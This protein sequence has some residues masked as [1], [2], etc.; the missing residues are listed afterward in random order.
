MYSLKSRNIFNFKAL[1][2]R[3]LPLFLT[4][5]S[6]GAWAQQYVFLYFP[7][8]NTPYFLRNN[9]G[10]IAR[11]AANTT[12]FGTYYAQCIFTGNS[13]NINQVTEFQNNGYYLAYGQDNY[14]GGV[15]YGLRFNNNYYTWTNAGNGRIHGNNRYLR[16]ANNQWSVENNNNPGSGESYTVLYAYT[17]N[18]ASLSGSISGADVLKEIGTSPYTISGTF[19]SQYHKFEGYR[20]PYYWYN[21]GIK[22]SAPAA[23]NV[24]SGTWSLTGGG[25]YASVNTSTGVITVSSLPASDIEMTLTCSVT[26][27]GSTATVS[28]KVILYASMVAA[29][30]ITRTTNNITLATD[31]HDATIYYTTDGSTP[32]SSSTAYSGP[33]NIEKL[34]YPVT[35]KAITIRDGMSSTVTSETYT[36]P[37]CERPVITISSDGIATIT[38]AT[39]GATIRVNWN[40]QDPS[41]TDGS[42]Y[43]GPF[44]VSNPSTVKAIAYKEGYE[45]SPIAI[46][47]F[48]NSGI[49]VD[50]KVVIDDREDHNWSYYQSSANLPTGYPVDY[51]SSPDPR[52]VKITYSGGSVTNASAVAISAL[53]GEDQNT[54]VYLKTL[55]K[56]VPGMTGN[57]PYTVIS[58]PF[59]KRPKIGS[60]YY[61]FGGWKVVSGGE[62]IVEYNNNAILPLDATIHFTGLDSNYS[63]NCTSAEI[64]FEATW[65]AATVKTGN[66]A[67]TFNGGT[68]E[69]NFWVLSGN[70]NIGNITVP[71]N[72]TV[73]ARY[74]DGTVSFNRNLTGTITANGNKAKVEFVNMNSTGNVTAA[75]YNFTMGRGIVNSANGGQLSGCNGD[76]DCLQTVKI[77]SGTYNNLYNFTSDLDDSRRCDQLLILGCDYDRVKNDNTKLLVRANMYLGTGIQLNRASNS[78]YARTYIKSGNLGSTVAVDNNYTGSGGDNTYYFSVGNTHNAGRRYLCME[79]GRID[80]IAGGMDESNNQSTTDRAFDLRVRGTAQIDGVVYG[81]AEFANAKGIRTMVF[82]GGTIN[83]WVAGGANGTRTTNGALTGATYLY[84]GGKTNVDSNNSNRVLNRAI[85]GNVFGAG[86]GFSN[87]SSSG[88]VLTYN[89][90]VVVADEAYVERGVYGGGSYG[91]TR[92]TSNIYVLGGTVDGKSGGVNG[93]EYSAVISGGVF[94]GACQNDGGTVN[95]TMKDGKVSA[96]GVYGGSNYTGTI[97]GNVTM[98][99][100]GGQVGTDATH[101]AN[102][103]GGGYGDLTRVSGSVDLTLGTTTQTT[104]GVVVYG[105]VYGGSALGYVNGTT[106]TDALHTYVTLNKG[107]IN[108]SLYGGGLGQKNGVNGGTSDVAANV[109]GSVQVKVYGGSVKKT[110]ADGS[111]GVY[112]ANNINGAPRHSVTVDI[113]GTDP[114][115]TAGEYALYAVYGGGNKADYTYGNGYPTVTVHNCDNS[116]EYVYG[117]G[118]AAA[119]ASTNVTIWGGNVIG[120]VFGGGNGTV[121]AANVTGNVQTKI[122]GGIIGKVFGGSNSQ[123]T[124][125]GTITVKAESKGENDGACLMKVTELYGGGNK[126]GSKAGAITIGCM[127]KGDMIDYVYGGSNDA[128]ITGDINLTMTGGRIGNL[129]GGNNTGSTITGKIS[130]EVDWDT[131]CTTSYLGNVYGGGNKAAYSAPTATPNYPQVTIKNATINYNVFGGGLGSTAVVTGNPIVTIGENVG[132]KRVDIT[133]DVYGGGDAAAVTGNTKILYQVAN[134]TASKLFGGGNAAGVSGNATIDMANGT[135]HK[136]IYGGCNSSGTI[137]GDVL[138]T[139]VNGTVGSATATEKAN[140]HGGGYG[141]ETKTN[142]NVEVNIGT[143]NGSGVTTGAALI[144]GDVYGG[145]ALG[146]VN[147]GT[148]DHTYVNLNSGTIYGDAYGGGLGNSET[149]ADVNGNVRLTQNGVI[150]VKSYAE[151]SDGTQ[152]QNADGSLILDA[153][154][155]FGCNNLNGSPKGTVLVLVNKTTGT[156]G[157]QRTA[158]EKLTSH[159]ASDHSYELQ[160]VYGGGNLAAYN[161]TNPTATGQYSTAAHSGTN[162]PLQVVIDGCQEVSIEYVYGGGNAAATPS[163]DVVVL[164]AYE[165]DYVFGGGNGKDLISR[166]GTNWVSQNGADV[167]FLNSSNYGTGISSATIWGGTIHNAFGGSNTKG[168][169]RTTAQVN[170]DEEGSPCP[171]V[172][173]EVY[174]GGNEAYMDGNA[175]INLGCISYLREIYGGSR[176]ADVGSDVVLTIT[177]GHFDRVF[178]GNNKGGEIHGS[179]TVNIEETGCHPITIGELYG[180]GNQAAYSVMDGGSQSADPVINIKSFTS[181]GRVFGGGLGEEAEVTGNPTVNINE[182]VGVNANSDS[183]YPGTEL[184]LSDNTK[185]TLPA[186]TKGAIGAIGTVYGGG[187]AAPVKGNTTVKIGTEANVTYVSGDRSTAAVEG[188]NIT[189]NVFG[190]GLGSTAKVSG[191]TDVKVGR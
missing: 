73:S 113:Y 17:D 186:H 31:V 105:D 183:A 170:L 131:S 145:S 42:V 115:P 119:V 147:S 177:S 107:T 157:Q 47:D 30:T 77:E 190:G 33:F 79:G 120:N 102:I 124:I 118:N 80:G 112:G 60:T 92:N 146:Q 104:P 95:I 116:I 35:V 49:T 57:Y 59:S 38:C 34:Q 40:G 52:N 153:G 162:Q 141:S 178:G 127:G 171:L 175:N 128:P 166:D 1:F 169:V 43:I 140:V 76:K 20:G 111:G 46:Q 82:T 5:V 179:I 86:C 133:G 143:I 168:N 136:G 27:N 58:N 185:V 55:E 144:Y 12:D 68:Y 154:R 182:R 187:N 137:G 10:T 8:N 23:S 11:L 101:T 75:G 89:T 90:N 65:T 56:T 15:N 54:M 103:H 135:V 16:F 14:W 164:G 188:A 142:G 158:Q 13:S 163:T 51:L 106:A 2:R 94:G 150:L 21:N 29:P 100:D 117:G 184:T 132:S 172:I 174:G 7:N 39:E 28:K 93:T 98:Q 48:A 88:Q 32:T 97:S 53:T 126:A 81:A 19:T 84:V 173:N 160:A 191:N 161:P 50:K 4:L 62:Y 61:G 138:V 24:T 18:A 110:S 74:P 87:E 99:I 71:A 45:E 181:I 66:T 91:F 41:T 26:Q 139:L 125:G 85:G 165:I 159:T 108:G 67:Q 9:N 123:G 180:C 149:A 134:N 37:L 83:G 151:K 155:I 36:A 22:T 167:G 3:L 156:T 148:E 72:C 70:Q 96:G 189:G 152:V 63:P 129:F 6:V 109:Y 176:D 122:Y 69:T 44:S 114:A 130:V 25:S 78:L 121:T 64:V